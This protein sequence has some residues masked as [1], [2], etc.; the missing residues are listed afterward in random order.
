MT[1]YLRRRRPEP[2]DTLKAAALALGV[3]VS[4]AAA[5]F[6]VGRLL[7]TR[8]VLGHGRD[9]G[10][11]GKGVGTDGRDANPRSSVRRGGAAGP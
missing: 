3:G 10:S 7:L 6:Y 9:G 5:T 4:A 11:R 1:R 8:E 2:G